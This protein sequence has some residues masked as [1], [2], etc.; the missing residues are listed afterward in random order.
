MK[1]FIPGLLFGLVWNTAL[2]ADEPPALTTLSNPKIVYIV[3]GT[4]FVK[5]S[6]GGITAVVVNNEAV[7][8]DILPGHKAGYS[9]VGSL[10]H[11]KQPRNLFVPA[12]AG[13]NFEHIHDGTTR[14]RDILFEPRKFPMELRVVN[15][16]TAELYQAPTGN[17]KL[18]SCTR[19]A[20]LPDGTIEMTFECIPRA[21][22]YKNGYIGLFWASYINAPESK[23]IYFFGMP[24]DQAESEPGWIRGVTPKHGVLATHIGA[25]DHRRFKHDDNFPLT[26]VFNRSQHY[27]AEPW[28]YA[29]SHGMAYVLMFRD[30]DQVRLSQSPSGGG[31]DNPAWDFQWFI[32]NP[33]VDKRY[34]LVL[35]AAYVPFK[36]AE[37]IRKVAQQQRSELP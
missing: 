34:Q 21:D 10:T 2:V 35:R 28:Y 32:E 17:W 24:N 16:H 9:G 14:D 6:R 13:L 37:E 27:F 20:L 11:E 31:K 15:D 22:T 33:E 8:N 18:E 5:L 12:Y 26:L 1:A 30:Q 19:Y 4:P 3:P 29:V 23:D 36:S 25:Y 7:D